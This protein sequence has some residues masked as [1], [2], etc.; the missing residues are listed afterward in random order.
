M[1]QRFTKRVGALDG[2]EAFLAVARHLNFRKAAAELGVSASA[3]GQSV[4]TL[5]ARLG[6]PLLLRSTRS[7]GLTEAGAHLLAEAGPAFDVIGAAAEAIG[8][9]GGRPSGRLRIAVARGAVPL[10]LRP[11]LASFH[12]AYP[13]IELEIAA[14]EQIVDIVK[15]GFDAGIRFGQLIAPDMIAIRL[16]PGFGVRAVGSPR[17]LD[18]FAPPATIADLARHRCLRFRRTDGAIAP[19]RLLGE[20]GREI[21]AEVRGP[22]IAN[23]FPTLR[24]AAIDG[25]GLTQLP[26]PM[27]AEPM[28][29]G[30]LVPV[31]EAHAPTLPGMFLFHPGRRQLLPKLR[32]FIDHL[33]DHVP[34]LP[35]DR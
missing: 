4:R 3:V 29:A 16:T 33:R 15:E 21:E 7:V 17:Y 10:L 13:D 35:A 19:W 11:I 25:V 31:L 18:R 20:D 28:A 8:G 32:A 1:K 34:T 26:H 12:D 9:L 24:D 22:L 30:R 23:D 5:E 27:A 2:I 14:S 6:A